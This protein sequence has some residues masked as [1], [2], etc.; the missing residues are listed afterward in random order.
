MEVLCDAMDYEF[1]KKDDPVFHFGDKGDKLYIILKGKV[2]ICIPKVEEE[3]FEEIKDAENL[4][5]NSLQE[6]LELKRQI[7]RLI[8]KY[9][10]KSSLNLFPRASEKENPNDQDITIKIQNILQLRQRMKSTKRD[11]DYN[12]VAEY[13]SKCKTHHS[14]YFDEFLCLFKKVRTMEPGCHFGE[15]ALSTSL[16]R[17]AS[18]F[19]LTDLHIITLS[20]ENYKRIFENMDQELKKKI[21][22]FARLTGQSTDEAIIKFSY[23]FRERTYKYGQKIFEEGEIPIEVFVVK[24]GEVQ[25][26]FFSFWI[27]LNNFI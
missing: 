17:G 19:A 14:L 4:P 6:S 15:L 24:E 20:K 16:L 7:D 13:A 12:L 2:D 5:S 26:T 10:G 3:I 22:F 23:S 25:A 11:A 18:A 8:N 9:R 21:R 1:V 27:Y